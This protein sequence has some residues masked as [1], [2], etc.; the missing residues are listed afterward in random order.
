MYILID[1]NNFFASCERVFDPSLNTKPVVVL[2]NN[3]GCVV[4]RSNEAKALNIPMGIPYFKARPIIENYKVKVFSANFVLYG[5]MSA[6]VMDTIDS[7]DI[8]MEQ[9][10]IDEAFLFLDGFDGK[11]NDLGHKI[12]NRVKQ[13]TGIPVSVG[14]ANTKTLA[15]LANEYSKKNP[16]TGGVLDLSSIKNLDEIFSKVQVGDVWGIGRKSTQKLNSINIKTVLDFIKLPPKWVK[17]QLTISG[18]RT[19]ME[20]KGQECIELEDALPSKKTI[21]SS[22]SFGKPIRNLGE[23]Q[24]A[25]SLYIARAAEKLRSQNSLTNVLVVYITTGY[26][27]KGEHYSTSTTI[28]LPRPT[29]STAELTHHSNTALKEIYRSGYDYKKSGVIL[30]DLSLSDVSQ[31]DLFTTQYT[32]SK[33]QDLMK[34]LDKIN[35]KHGS[36]TLKFAA[37]GIKQPWAM[38]NNFRSK[39]YTTSWT[40]LPTVK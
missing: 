9:Y 6:R 27:G 35:Q 28:K 40:Q 29:A 10:S 2:S 11:L 31:L 36:S 39:S 17:E 38:K 33:D 5:D 8:P 23:L 32:G 30:C 4:A 24:E 20:L 14:I 16:E 34:A 12:R 18:L 1:C 13:N 15:K 7:F 19:Q 37:Q 3:D 22:R 25:S 21:T 26:H